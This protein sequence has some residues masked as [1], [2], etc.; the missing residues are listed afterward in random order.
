MPLCT[1]TG[2]QNYP[3]PAPAG[4]AGYVFDGVLHL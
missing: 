3:P 4:G 2:F 1:L